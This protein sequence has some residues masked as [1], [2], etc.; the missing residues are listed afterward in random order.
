MNTPCLSCST[1]GGARNAHRARGLCDRCYNRLR[2]R[3]E[4]TDYPAISR[5]RD[6]VLTELD[7]L[8]FDPRRSIRPQMRALAPRLGMSAAALEKAWRRAQTERK[9]A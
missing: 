2:N 6:E 5:T 3:G 9:A 7:H 8:G 4:L 1:R